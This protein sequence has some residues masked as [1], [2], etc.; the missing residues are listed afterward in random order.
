MTPEQREQFQQ[1][2]RER[3]QGRDGGGRQGGPGGNRQGANAPARS[4]AMSGGATTI[5]A[6]FAPLATVTRRERVW[7]WVNKEL[8]LINV[9]TG[10]SDGTW[11]EIV[12]GTGLQAG[13]EVVTNIVT[14]LEPAPRPGQQNPGGAQNPLMGPQR[15]GPGGGRGR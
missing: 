15:G 13:T 14:G 5:D 2:M 11:T 1:R 12:E 10:I 9:V 8:K 6:L 7:L 3:G 4:A